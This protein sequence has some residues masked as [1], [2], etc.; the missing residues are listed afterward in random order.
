MS[1][2]PRQR[3]R[4]ATPSRRAGPR[5]LAPRHRGSGLARVADAGATNVRF[6]ARRRRLVVRAPARTRQAGGLVDLLPRPVAED[7]APQAAPGGPDLRGARRRQAR[8]RGCLA[9][10]H[11]LGRLR[12]GD[13]RCSTPSRCS[14]AASSRAGPIARS[15]SSS[16]RASRRTAT[17]TDLAYTRS[18]APGGQSGR[19][20]SNPASSRAPPPGRARRRARVRAAAP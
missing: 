11:R 6:C 4:V 3:S 16:A 19:P 20:S 15:P 18:A 14:T 8:P 1:A 10:R 7:T 2:R 13:A 5:G 9:A 12:A 17:I